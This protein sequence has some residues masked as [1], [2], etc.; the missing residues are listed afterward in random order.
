MRLRKVPDPVEYRLGRDAEE[1]RDAVHRDATEVP[2]N[3]V[4]FHRAWLPA[5]SR[6]GELIS[7]LFAALFGFASNRAIVDETVTLAFGACMHQISPPAGVA[8]QSAGGILPSTDE[9]TT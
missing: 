3:G 8:I 4:R 6:A 1:E 7:T 5:R 9:N 2:Q